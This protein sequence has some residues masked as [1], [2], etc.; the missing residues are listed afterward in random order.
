MSPIFESWEF[1]FL[2]GIGESYL[3][4]S[5]YCKAKRER[6]VNHRG[7]CGISPRDARRASYENEETGAQSFSEKWH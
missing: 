6:Y 5:R 2:W 1:W 4:K 3:G 7:W